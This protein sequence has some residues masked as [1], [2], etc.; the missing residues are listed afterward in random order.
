MAANKFHSTTACK[1]VVVL[2]IAAVAALL[3]QA[4]PADSNDPPPCTKSLGE[5]ETCGDWC[6]KL[7][8]HEG[9]FANSVCCCGSR[10]RPPQAS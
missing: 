1:A 8:Y 2:A 5:G 4:T 3:A 10:L 7:G 9:S 6:C